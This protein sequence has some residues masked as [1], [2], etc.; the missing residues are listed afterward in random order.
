ME[1]SIGKSLKRQVTITHDFVGV[2]VKRGYGWT[3]GY[4]DGQTD[5]YP[6]GQISGRTDGRMFGRTDGR[7]RG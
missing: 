3:D 7:I 1:L 5:G 6:D 4:P 2:R